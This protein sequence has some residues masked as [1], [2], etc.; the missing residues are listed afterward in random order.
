MGRIWA[1][2]VAMAF[3]IT[4]S[5]TAAEFS[6]EAAALPFPPDARKLEFTAWSGDISF[7]TRST[8]NAVVAFYLREMPKRGWQLDK[9]EVEVDDDDI[10]LVFRHGEAEVEMDFR[11]RSS[12]TA[13]SFDCEELEF[14]G[15]DDPSALKAK[16]VPVPQATVFF[17]QT[18][19]IPENVTKFTY[20]DDGCLI[21]S[22]QSL[23]EAFDYYTERVKK[24]GFRESRRPLIDSSRM[25]TEFKKGSAK[26]SVNVFTDA[27]GSRSVVEFKDKKNEPR[28]AP[29]PPVA[30]LPIELAGE[31]ASQQVSSGVR[32]TGAPIAAEEKLTPVDVT[33]NQ[34]KAVVT[35]GGKKYVFPH[36]VAHRAEGYADGIT[37]VTFSSKPIPYNKLQELVRTDET[38]SFSQLYDF[39]TPDY[40]QLNHGSYES[41]SFSIPGVGIGGKQMD[42]RTDKTKIENGRLVGT[43]T[44]APQEVFR[45]QFSFTATMDVGIITPET[46]LGESTAGDPV[47]DPVEIAANSVLDESPVPWPGGVEDVSRAGTD[48]R[49]TYQALVP[50]PRDEVKAFYIKQLRADGW[51]YYA[52]SEDTKLLS[53]KNDDNEVDFTL[54][55]EGTQT[56]IEALVR[57]PELA[58]K[59]GILPKPRQA[60]LVL[61]N[62]HSS[63]V[64][65]TIGKTDY[66]LKPGQGAD[67]PKTALNYSLSPGTYTIS[68]KIPG[69]QPQTERLQLTADTTWGIIALPT[70]GYMP[71][72]M[73]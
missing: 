72:Q 23:K 65:Y 18:F 29:L 8:L 63:P 47:E 25:Y 20:Q 38:A 3:G 4:G 40:L 12:K 30:S 58:R 60:R 43:F 61:A 49:K 2:V 35:F 70:G 57:Y 32:K 67:D 11:G 69:E 31:E 66:K 56:R 16:G 46:K 1:A 24:I 37:F 34:G 53:F 62:A 41:F 28:V 73:Y 36:V 9:S 33:R 51:K 68:I 44:M 14:N 7:E 42:Q 71:M 39:S 64:V 55:A 10:E 17:Q 22:Q 15:I 27:V 6:A 48:F 54:S 19:P 50:M 5:V 52:R 21:Y 26:V 45:K 13:V 59:M